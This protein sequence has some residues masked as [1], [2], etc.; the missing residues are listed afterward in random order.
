MGTP[1]PQH[2][3]WTGNDGLT[4][5]PLARR[6]RHWQAWQ[7]LVAANVAAF[8]AQ[9]I[10]GVPASLRYGAFTVQGGLFGLQL[11]RWATCLFLHWDPS[12][13]IFNML[14]LWVFGPIV[15]NRLRPARFLAIYSASGVG[16]VGGYLLLYR[17]AF[18]D[19]R[20]WSELA[21]ASGCVFGVIVAA[22]HLEPNRPFRLVLPPVTL[23]L[24]TIAWG[25]A[26]F[27]VVTIAIH[28]ANAGGEA[29]HLGGAAVGFVLVRNPS[30]LAAVGIG[31]KPRRFWRPGDP[32]GNF[33]RPDA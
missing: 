20:P 2:M 16:A 5:P 15:E 11:W 24:V 8:V 30:W 32:A 12:H 10:V 23:R 7:W 14:G 28:G 17:L 33:F 27:A 9:L 19:V 3:R 6:L 4:G 22:A 13:L 21:G 29:A 1:R 25:L 18:L 26:A 31:P